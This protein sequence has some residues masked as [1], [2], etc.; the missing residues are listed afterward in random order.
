MRQ[1]ELSG[2]QRTEGPELRKVDL[3]LYQKL[4]K[5]RKENEAAIYGRTK[6]VG[7]E[8][9][10]ILAYTRT[11]KG[12]KLL[13]AANFSKGNVR[14]ILPDWTE[15]A[16]LLLNNYEELESNNGTAVLKPYQALV[17]ERVPRTDS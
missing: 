5:I 15:N 7:H 12:K 13:I 17:F 10:R 1:P 8:N 11:Y 4:L 2:N 6:E 9:K 16:K 3:P 14:C